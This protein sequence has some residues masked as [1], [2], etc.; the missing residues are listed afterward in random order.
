[1]AHWALISGKDTDAIAAA[2]S[3]VAARLSSAGVT[4]GGFVQA[5]VVE[6]SGRKHYDVVR[7]GTGERARISQERPR[8]AEGSSCTQDFL[9]EGFNAAR[10]WAAEDAAR[11]EVLVIDGLNKLEAGGEGHGPTLVEALR[12][13]AKVVLLGAR[14]RQLSALMERF[15][16]PEASLVGSLEPPLDAGAVERFTATL[17]E[18]LSRAGE[19]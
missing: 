8:P 5:R 6:E 4:V 18:A 14:D 7:L 19:R 15:V 10:R 11:V 16:L 9:D 13:K 1:M 17:V 2:L 12:S 3:D